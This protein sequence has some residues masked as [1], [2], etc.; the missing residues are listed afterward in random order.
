MEPTRREQLAQKVRDKEPF[1]LDDRVY[2][3]ELKILPPFAL[4]VEPFLQTAQDVKDFFQKRGRV[5][6]DESITEWLDG[7]NVPK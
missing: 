2:Y 4:N 5:V 1:T 7:M 3:H 6:T